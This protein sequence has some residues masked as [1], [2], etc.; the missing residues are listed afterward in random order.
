MKIEQ[1][2][3]YTRNFKS[4]LYRHIHRLLEA[5]KE[6]VERIVE[7]LSPVF[8]AARDSYKN[9][10]KIIEGLAVSFYMVSPTGTK[11]EKTFLNYRVPDGSLCRMKAPVNQTFYFFDKNAVAKLIPK[12]NQ[13]IYMQ[14]WV[15]SDVSQPFFKAIEDCPFTIVAKV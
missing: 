12:V 9:Q 13:K 8:L 4:I 7:D 1:A 2:A 6:V 3:L 15:L 14:I 11:L 5:D 10:E